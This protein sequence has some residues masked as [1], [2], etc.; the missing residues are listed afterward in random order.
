[1]TL[2]NNHQHFNTEQDVRNQV[3]T[4]VHNHKKTYFTGV[5]IIAA[6][7]VV[8]FLIIALV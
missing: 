1:M 3:V 6:I 5:A 7:V 8:G 2:E 4:D